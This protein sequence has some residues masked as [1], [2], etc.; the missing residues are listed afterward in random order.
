MK[1]FKALIPL[2]VVI[3][4]LSIYGAGCAPAETTTGK[5]AYNSKDWVKAEAE[6]SKGL[7]IDKSDAEA[8][9]MLGYCQVE[10]GKFDEATKSFKSCLSVSSEWGNQIKAFWIDKYN[11]GIANFNDGTKLLGKKDQEGAN[12]SFL[13]AITNFKGAAS[14]IPDSISSYQLIA[15]AYNYMGETDKALALYQSILDKSKSKEDAIQIARLLYNVGIKERQAEKYDKAIT[16][17]DN[18]L[19]I[20]FLPKDNIYY[21][22]S[23]FNLG[24]ANYQIAVKMATDGKTKAEYSP[25]LNNTVKF[26]EELTTS[27]KTKE[28]LKDSYEILINAYD[29]LGMNDKKDD[30][31]KKKNALQ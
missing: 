15:D 5:L 1:S 29:A 26:L 21:E 27:S 6:L 3:I 4:I 9:Y 24:Y 30:A 14:I 8:W 2:F 7:A 16:I 17:F 19:K 12:K 11:A 20:Q 13:N 22:T 25:Y 31:Q 18:V 23:L 28:L 10:L